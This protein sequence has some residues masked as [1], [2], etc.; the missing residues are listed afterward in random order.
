MPKF[1]AQFL[2]LSRDYDAL[3][4][5]SSPDEKPSPP[6]QFPLQG[7]RCPDV[8]LTVLHYAL[9]SND[10]EFVKMLLGE[11]D[12]TRSDHKNLAEHKLIKEFINE[13]GDKVIHSK[14]IIFIKIC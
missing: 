13:S 6:V 10:E 11:L 1:F 2:F 12:T 3:Q 9:Q 5:V 8:A 7:F 4:K 14:F